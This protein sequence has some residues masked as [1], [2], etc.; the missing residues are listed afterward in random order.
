MEAAHCA[1]NEEERGGERRRQK[2]QQN[3]CAFS[4]LAFPHSR[5]LSL[6]LSFLCV[7]SF[8][9]L[10]SRFRSH[11]LHLARTHC[12]SHCALRCASEQRSTLTVKIQW[13]RSRRRR[14]CRC[15]AS[16]AATLAATRLQLTSTK[17]VVVA[18]ANIQTSK[19]TQMY[20]QEYSAHTA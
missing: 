1:Q 14:R 2:S 15:P 17:I 8:G 16:A 6:F 3:L 9:A 13:Q 12:R 18:D 20:G 19:Q 10:C 5:N 4:F 7:H 11:T